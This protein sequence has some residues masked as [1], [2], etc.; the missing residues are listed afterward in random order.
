MFLSCCWYW[1]HY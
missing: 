1:C